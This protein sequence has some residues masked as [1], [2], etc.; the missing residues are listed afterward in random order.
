MVFTHSA[1][2]T[3]SRTLSVL[4][5]LLQQTL[6]PCTHPSPPPAIPL[7]SLLLRCRDAHLSFSSAHHRLLSNFLIPLSCRNNEWVGFSISPSEVRALAWWG[8]RRLMP[9]P[10]RGCSGLFSLLPCTELLI[11]E[12]T[13]LVAAAPAIMLLIVLWAA[14]QKSVSGD[15][16]FPSNTIETLQP[17]QPF[18]PLTEYYF[19]GPEGAIWLRAPEIIG[20]GLFPVIV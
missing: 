20:S 12:M 18:S 11:K 16:S 4:S 6:N 3:H 1:A 13:V 2:A 5:C 19:G 7:L 8:I 17:L 14:T 15:F 9:G 10:Q